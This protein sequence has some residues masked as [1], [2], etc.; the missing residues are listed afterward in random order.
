MTFQ[1]EEVI[2]QEESTPG[3][4]LITFNNAG[5]GELGCGTA[6][7]RCHGVSRR[8]RQG[9]RSGRSQWEHLEPLAWRKEVQGEA[10]SYF[11]FSEEELIKLILNFQLTELRLKGKEVVT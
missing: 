9:W 10:G 8:V 7:K 4:Q 2:S 6:S 11:L 5:Q 3:D 1:N